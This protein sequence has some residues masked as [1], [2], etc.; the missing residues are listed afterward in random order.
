MVGVAMKMTIHYTNRFAKSLITIINYW[1]DDLMISPEN[2]AKF[3]TH[4]DQKI[5]LLSQFPEMGQDITSLYGFSQQTYRILIGH[6]YELFYRID[7]RH[8]V[9]LVGSIHGTSQMKVKF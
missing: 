8:K 3:T 1:H 2:I 9:I 6:S 5:S 4:I 7:H